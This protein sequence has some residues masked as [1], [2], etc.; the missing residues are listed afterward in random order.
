MKA[1]LLLQRRFAYVGHAM[2]AVLRKKY[3]VQDFCGYVYQRDSLNFLKT[4]KEINYA[5]LLLDEDIHKQYKDEPLDLNYL[6]W[7]EKE[8]GIPNLWPYIEIDRVVRRGQLVREYPYDRPKYSHEEM[9]RILQVKARAM[10][11]FLERQKPDFVLLSVIVDIATLL[12]YHA[13]KKMGIKTLFIQTTRVGARYSL[14]TNHGNLSYISDMFS[15]LQK[16]PM[17]EIKEIKMAQA[18]LEEF[19]ANPRPHST[20]DSPK[21]RPIGRKNQFKFLRPENIARS[22]VWNFK[23]IYDYLINPH[24][25]DFEVIKPWHYFIDKIKRKLRVLIGFNDLYDAPDLEEDFAFFPMHLEPEMSI[26]LFAPFYTDQL[27]LIKQIARSLPIACKLYVK[28]HPAMFGYR[29]RRFYKE[30]KKIP[31]V[32]LVDP[33]L[34]SFPITKNAKLIITINS[35]AGWEAVLLK[36]PA[37][38]FGNV[39]YNALPMAKKCAAIEDLPHIVKEQLENFNYSEPALIN[40]IA[41]IYKES[42]DLDL[43]QIWDIEGGSNMEKKQKVVEPFVDYLAKKLNLAALSIQES[44]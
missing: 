29:T 21:K 14:T 10:I 28:E 38:T 40:L 1:C 12:M 27:W 24:K 20:T 2:A 5:E 18:F 36:K 22:L 25:D 33:S 17:P 23:I 6:R 35:T 31:N 15:D 32:R 39:F 19:R 8:Y 16:N 7:L 11:K 37:V 3:G 44:A 26:S 30:L 13:A 34:E 42:A 43:V 4:Q 9:M 41:A